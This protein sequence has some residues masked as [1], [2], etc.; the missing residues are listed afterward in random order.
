VG[1]KLFVTYKYGDTNV[2]RLGGAMFTKVRDYVTEMQ[3]LLSDSH[4]NKG[5]LDNESLAQF[6]DDA[7]YS[8][9]RDK[10]YDSSGTIIVISSG[11]RDGVRLDRDQWMPWEISYSLKEHSRRG[12]KSGSNALLA[13]VLPD[14]AGSYR[15]FLEEN[16]CE[17]C[18]VIRF[19][20]NTLFR[21][22]ARN[23]FNAKNSSR[24]TCS[25]HYSAEPSHTGDFSYITSVKWADFVHDPNRYIENA[26]RINE[27]IDEYTIVKGVD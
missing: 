9:L 3:T 17:H 26:Y 21:I 12:R 19:Q 20:T 10:I 13:V 24:G 6:R 5:E 14:T 18:N 16:I 25:S 7:I 8:K 2:A 27:Q 15:Y 11:M 23:M 22:M 1:H 4:I